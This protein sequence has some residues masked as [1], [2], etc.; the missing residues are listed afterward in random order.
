MMVPKATND[1]NN[2]ILPYTDGTTTQAS[3]GK[4]NN[5]EKDVQLYQ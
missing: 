2:E 3:I 5:L 4:T 1:K